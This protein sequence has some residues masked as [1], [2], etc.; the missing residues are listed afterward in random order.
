MKFM[1]SAG[2]LILF[3]VYAHIKLLHFLQPVFNWV[4]EGMA[5]I[6]ELIDWALVPVVLVVKIFFKGIFFVFRPIIGL[7]TP[8]QTL[9]HRKPGGF[10]QRSPRKEKEGS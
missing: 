6:N 1:I 9:Y 5:D 4:A 3:V 2:T 7:F 8:N 10:R